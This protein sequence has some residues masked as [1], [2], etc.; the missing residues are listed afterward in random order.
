M[1]TPVVLNIFIAALKIVASVLY[2]ISTWLQARAG[3]MPRNTP[4][5][6]TL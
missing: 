3:V 5:L 6:G 4:G 2:I 1:R